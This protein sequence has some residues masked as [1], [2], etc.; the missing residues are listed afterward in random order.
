M[1][2]KKAT[3]RQVRLQRFLSDAGVASRRR[4]EEL[5]EAGRVLVNDAIVDR[6]PAFVDPARD[7]V[8]VDGMP[9][10]IKPLEYFLMHKPKGVV[11]TNRDPGGRLRA[12]DLLPPTKVHL[13][14]VGRLDADSTGLLLLTNDGELAEQISH[15]RLGVPKVYRVE[16]RG[17][18]PSDI[19][20]RMKKGVHLAE[21]KVT[22]SEVEIVHRSRQSSVLKITLCEGRNR[23]VR[24]MLARLG[25][26]VKTL[27]RVQIGPL[28]VKGLP[29]GACRRLTARELAELRR[30]IW[31]AKSTRSTRTACVPRPR[32]TKPSARNPQR[33]AR[34]DVARGGGKPSRPGQGTPAE[35]PKPR[36]RLVT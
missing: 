35:R 13:N 20:A 14:V 9:A 36:R 15:P 31:A 27:K 7:R 19:V 11:C 6:L 29:V 22:A 8:V 30:T 3:S 32:A 12:V 28:H 34:T 26:T 2:R 5:I 17:Q 18:V 21:G 33:A 24:R 23:Q 16:V 25:H 10:R 4:A 1:T